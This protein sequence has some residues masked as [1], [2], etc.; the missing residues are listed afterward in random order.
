MRFLFAENHVGERYRDFSSI[1]LKRAIID[2]RKSAV[3]QRPARQMNSRIQSPIIDV[4]V[5]PVDRAIKG[6]GLSPPSSSFD[7]L[8][9]V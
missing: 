7:F 9:T 8:L 6:V 4:S 3:E 2:D 5:H 1:I